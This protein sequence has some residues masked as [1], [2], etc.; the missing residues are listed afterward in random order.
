MYWQRKEKEE[1]KDKSLRAEIRQI[2]KENPCY[3]YRRITAKL[4]QK[5]IKVNH[6]KVLRISKEEN[7]QVCLLYTSPRPRD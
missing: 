5:G 4:H 6:K 3:G 1:D 2:A 7:L